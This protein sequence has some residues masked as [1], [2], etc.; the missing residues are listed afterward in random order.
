[1]PERV[2]ITGGTGMVGS[3]FARINDP[4]YEFIRVGSRDYDL[5]N[6]SE[7]QQM[8]RDHTPQHVIH[9]AAKVGG[10]KG[11][12]DYVGDF[13][14]IN[15]LIN[16]QVLEAARAAG[17]KKLI[18]M[19]STC[20]FPDDVKY[21]I[22][23]D[24]IHNGR[25]HI[26]NFGYAHAKR[27]LEVQSRAYRQQF[28]SNFITVVPNN[29]YGENDNFDLDCS[30]VVPAT[31]RKFYEAKIE[32]K[33]S[34]E[35]W[36][37]GRPLR[38]FTY[39]LDIAHDIVNILTSYNNPAPINIG[40]PAEISIKDLAVLISKHIGYKGT[41]AWNT[42]M[43]QGQFRK[44]FST[45]RYQAL[46]YRSTSYTSLETGI[47]KTCGWFKENYPNIRGIHT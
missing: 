15:S 27:M 8:F 9:L 33:D 14:R 7:C 1:M 43:P 20:I 24:Q 40:F 21:P 39:S 12:T 2:L 22:T 32:S 19:L 41:T 16:T 17:V 26:S 36:G 46:G 38:E 44:P 6:W 4:A 28:G 45:D 13:F 10:V 31:I 37:D 11:N 47:A 29:L 35:M 25:P 5:I 34:V 3:A 42:A 30:H 18:S 23:E